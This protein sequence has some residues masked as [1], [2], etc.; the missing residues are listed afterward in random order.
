MEDYGGHMHARV[1]ET[2]KKETA[3]ENARKIARGGGRHKYAT[4]SPPN[5]TVVRNG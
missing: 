4:K 5:L 1:G 2:G 3:K